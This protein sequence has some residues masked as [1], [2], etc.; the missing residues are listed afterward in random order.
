MPGS[1]HSSSEPDMFD[2]LVTFND[3]AGGIEA[4]FQMKGLRTEAEGQ[5]DVKIEIVISIRREKKNMVKFCKIGVSLI[6]V[7]RYSL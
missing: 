7:L 1:T 2:I 4:S 5:S 3:A 6:F